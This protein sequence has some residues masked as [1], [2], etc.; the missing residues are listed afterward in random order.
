MSLLFEV[1]DLTVI[2]GKTAVLESVSFKVE[3][4][5]VIAV[6]GPNGAGKTTLLRAL[7]GTVPYEGRIIWHQNPR[8]GYV[9]QRFD[10]DRTYPL[11]VEELFLLKSGSRSLW[12]PTPAQ[13]GEIKKALS[14]TEVEQLQKHKLGELSS[15]Q[16]Q[17]VFIAYGLFGAPELLLFDEPT[18]GID[19]GA[20]MTV[21]GL[22]RDIAQELNLTMLVVSH[23]LSVVYTYAKKV[24]CLN[25]T[26]ACFGVP[27]KVLTP[28]QLQSLYGA[29]AD[30]YG[31]EH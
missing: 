6:I 13:S 30:F 25:K 4:G 14:H 11:T 26:M 7:L 18:A 20:E 17:R 3:K 1:Q 12:A 9:P 29:G 5:D 24:V 15:G 21:Y 10:F 22:L 31:H 16:L 8:I 27:Q 19:I 28:E 2:L 23:E